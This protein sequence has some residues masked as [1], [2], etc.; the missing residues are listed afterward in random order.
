[1]SKIFLLLFFVVSFGS[2]AQEY[3]QGIGFA[4]IIGYYKFAQ[5]AKETAIATGLQYRA[6]LLWERDS[7]ATFAISSYPLLGM[8]GIFQLI[9]DNQFN[10]L[11]FELPVNAEYYFGGFDYGSCIGAG[12]SI[13]SIRNK[14]RL[15]NTTGLIIGPQVAVGLKFS[16]RSV[17]KEINKQTFGFRLS[18]TQ[19][20][21]SNNNPL[22]NKLYLP[23]A[24]G[25]NMYFNF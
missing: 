1:M 24:I 20:L 6:S 11:S 8:S 13:I 3:R 4:S 9:N 16:K 21:N 15:V 12:F 5:N 18:F 10:G 14:S 2:I 7:T 23:Y 22:D 19:G 17:F 25:L